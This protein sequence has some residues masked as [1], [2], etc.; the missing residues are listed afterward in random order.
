MAAN[1]PIEV[2]RSFVAIVDSGSM[3]KASDRVFLSQSAI[4]LQVKRLEEM[5][6]QS[7]F[8]REGRRLVLTNTGETFLGYARRLLALN[9]EAVANV[10]GAA[11]KGPVRVG[12][13]QDFAE[14]LFT[15]AL[16]A[17]STLNPDAVLHARVAGTQELL[18]AR[19]AGGL[20]L[21]LGFAD[22]NTPSPL[23]VDP[24]I[25]IGDEELAKRPVVPLAVLERP[26]R[27]REA[28]INALERS[29]RSYRIV[30][31]TPNLA[32]LKAGVNAGLGLS[33]RSP[34]L[35]GIP[36]IQP[37]DALPALPRV[38]TQLWTGREISKGAQKLGAILRKSLEPGEEEG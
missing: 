33:A 7:L 11:E 23:R 38:A 21:V 26:C 25:W 10:S 20:D 29:G 3:L 18:E 9:D 17:F 14:S 36:Q 4:S 22:E 27:F 31:E 35:A 19:D 37:G 12:M 13:V 30:I 15:G 32:T 16:A 8:T 34:L 5:L 28:A 1:L 6:Q 24:M 2:L